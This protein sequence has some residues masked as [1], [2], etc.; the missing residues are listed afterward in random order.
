VLTPICWQEKTTPSSISFE[1][2]PLLYNLLNICKTRSPPTGA[3]RSTFSHPILNCKQFTKLYILLTCQQIGI[4]TFYKFCWQEKTTPSSISFELLPLL[5]LEFLK[6]IQF[7]NNYDGHWN[8][9]Q[10]TCSLSNGEPI[11]TSQVTLSFTYPFLLCYT[12]SLSTPILQD[13]CKI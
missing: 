10:H 11:T 12:P 5:Y 7:L 1:L 6:K 13:F 8:E 2:L 3:G 9:T 4:N